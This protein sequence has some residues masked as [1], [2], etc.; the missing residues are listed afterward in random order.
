MFEYALR[1]HQLLAMKDYDQCLPLL[2]EY[3]DYL[4]RRLAKNPRDLDA[5]CQLADIYLELREPFEMS[6]EVLH[7][8]VDEGGLD[9]HAMAR[10]YTD[11]AYFDCEDLRTGVV[12]GADMDRGRAYLEKA[13]ALSPDT[14][15]SYS[16]LGDLELGEGHDQRALVLLRAAAR[17]G[18]QPVYWYN[19]AVSLTYNGQ[20]KQAKAMLEKMERLGE[21]GRDIFYALA[22]CSHTLGDRGSA[23]HYLAMSY[24]ADPD[25]AD[26]RANLYYAC[27]EF[28]RYVDAYDRVQWYPLASGLGPY[29]YCLKALGRLNDCADKFQEVMGQQADMIKA[30]EQDTDPAWT[31]EDRQARLNDLRKERKDVESVYDRVVTEGVRPEAPLKCELTY[32]CYLADCVR[33]RD[34]EELRA[35]L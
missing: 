18:R 21:G 2:Q 27:G 25:P 19:Y 15:Y 8:L 7:R 3:R 11:L 30:C 24:A 26:D 13:V 22:V 33:H 12:S 14:P 16:A 5:G 9:D 10:V 31:D 17:R 1:L 29:F 6:Q 4:E 32:V 20:W 28:A 35:T 23:L 34:P